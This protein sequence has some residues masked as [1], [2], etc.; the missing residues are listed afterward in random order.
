MERLL[1]YLAIV[2]AVFVVL[3]QARLRPQPDYCGEARRLAAAVLAV[4]QSRGWI[5]DTY[6]LDGV[7]INGTGLFHP[8]CGITLSIPMANTSILSGYRLRLVILC[9]N[10]SVIFLRI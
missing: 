8:R 1:L 2:A 7:V 3:L 10:S 4:N 9:S 6:M 5:V